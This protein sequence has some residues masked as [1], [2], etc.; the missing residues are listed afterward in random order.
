[1]SLWFTDPQQLLL[2]VRSPSSLAWHPVPY[3]SSPPTPSSRAQAA[4]PRSVRSLPL[5]ACVSE[6]F[7]SSSPGSTSWE[8]QPGYTFSFCI[9]LTLFVSSH[10]G[11]NR[12]L[13]CLR[14]AF[15]VTADPLFPL[16]WT[17]SLTAAAWL[18]KEGSASWCLMSFGSMPSP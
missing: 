4:L 16:R 17:L 18:L 2:M 15:C 3:A 5:S 8:V 13:L 11:T 14:L 10:S 6:L 7:L 12:P 1:M 9:V